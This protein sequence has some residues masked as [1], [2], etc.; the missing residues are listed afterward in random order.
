MID[1]RLAGGG[2]LLPA[3]VTV[4]IVL[5]AARR[6]PA[7]T[8]AAW[9]APTALAVAYI[10]GDLVLR[11]SFGLPPRDV[12]RWTAPLTGLAAVAALIAGRWPATWRRW[13]FGVLLCAAMAGWMLAPQRN[14][15]WEPAAG[16]GWTAA[17]G[18]AALLMWGLLHAAG[19]CVAARLLIFCGGITAAA[20]AVCLAVSGSVMLGLSAGTLGVGLGV[21]FVVS[22]WAAVDMRW[23]PSVLAIAWSALAL[24]G[25]YYSYLPA[26]S[27]GLLAAC[28]AVPLAGRLPGLRR[29]PVAAAVILSLVVLALSALA[30]VLAAPAGE[31]TEEWSGAAGRDGSRAATARAAASA[32]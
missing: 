31:D 25:Y 16:W 30:G 3:V 10:A 21:L 22:L 5:V 19:Q 8:V 14:H 26:A 24:S 4:I 9:A 11:G 27:A 18:G 6:R 32:A 2:V 20:T 13:A 1:L 23:S 28:W 29:R 15:E 7:P 12:T 17:V